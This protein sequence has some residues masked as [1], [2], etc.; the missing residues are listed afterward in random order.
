M[1]TAYPERLVRTLFEDCRSKES[2][3]A[4][5][6]SAEAICEIFEIKL[7]VLKLGMLQEWLPPIEQ[8][9][10]DEFYGTGDRN[11]TTE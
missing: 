9:Q 1:L 5:N 3:Q 6:S 7:N 4:V 2:Y 10:Q 8:Y 11:G